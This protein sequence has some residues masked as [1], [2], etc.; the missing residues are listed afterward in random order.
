M[1]KIY[2]LTYHCA[3]NVG[4]MLQCFALAET[5]RSSGRSVEVID[6]RPEKVRDEGIERGCAPSWIQRRR[7]DLSGWAR[8]AYRAVKYLPDKDKRPYIV[9]GSTVSSFCRFLEDRLPLTPE[10]YHTE[11]ELEAFSGED[12]VFITGSDQVWNPALSGTPKAYL[13]DFVKAGE[14]DSYGASFGR[15]FVDR[16]YQDVLKEALSDF[17]IIS[18]REKSAVGIVR[19]AAGRQA[20]HVLDPVF[21]VDPGRW[22]DLTYPVRW[23]DPYI[24]V[25]RMEANEEIA[26]QVE[27]LKRSDPALK[28]AKFDDLEDAL[29]VDIDIPRKGPLDFLSYLFA[30]SCVVTN[31]FH[32]TAFSIIG[33]KRAA[34]VP[35]S[36]YNERIASLLDGVAVPDR[37]GVYRLDPTCYDRMRGPICASK[38]ILEE[39]CGDRQAPR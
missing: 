21:L 1:K 11:E 37:K 13:L 30:A 35:H 6:Y 25:Y 34:I 24:F 39:I 2:I 33:R 8:L 5:I 28:V 22:R 38:E 16:P 19:E 10:R 23:K 26:A 32:G 20:V 18:V 7:R 12:A 27:A 29:P 3:Y 36:A 14:K 17:H 9:G 31:S 15:A 4:A